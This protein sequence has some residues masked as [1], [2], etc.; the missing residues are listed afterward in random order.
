MALFFYSYKNL[1]ILLYLLYSTSKP[2][3][4]W[5]HLIFCFCFDSGRVEDDRTL[6]V[7]F[8]IGADNAI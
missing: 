1:L 5:L 7:S 3:V 6:L 2:L 8:T 4:T